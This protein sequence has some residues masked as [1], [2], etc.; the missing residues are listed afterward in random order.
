M[1]SEL[2]IYLQHH[3]IGKF[4]FYFSSNYPI[5]NNADN[6]DYPETKKNTEIINTVID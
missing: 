4:M 1:K 3:L 6:N 5:K 2:S